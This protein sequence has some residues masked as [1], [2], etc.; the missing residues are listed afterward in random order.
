[1]SIK[2]ISISIAEWS[3]PKCPFRKKRVAI[4]YSAC[5]CRCSSVIILIYWRLSVA[6]R[7]FGRNALRF[8]I[9]ASAHDTFDVFPLTSPFNWAKR[10]RAWVLPWCRGKGCNLGDL[11]V[12]STIYEYMYPVFGFVRICA[13]SYFVITLTT[14]RQ[15]L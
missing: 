2:N 14:K 7:A 1:M 3:I 15:F 11:P 5:G 12:L 10:P 8:A 6:S 4:S 9:N 13:I